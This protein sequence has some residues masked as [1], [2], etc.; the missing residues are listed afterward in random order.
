MRIGIPC[1]AAIVLAC[2]APSAG[3]QSRDGAEPT[4]REIPRIGSLLKRRRFEPIRLKTGWE[5]RVGLAGPGRVAGPWRILYCLARYA[6][7]GRPPQFTLD[8]K[9]RGRLLGPVVYR[10]ERADGKALLVGRHRARSAAPEGESLFAGGVPW[11]WKGRCLVEVLS[12]AGRVLGRT[13]FSAARPVPCYWHVFAESA[14]GNAWSFVVYSHSLA[15]MPHYD[16]LLPI[17]KAGGQ[18]SSVRRQKRADGTE[19]LLPEDQLPTELLW[20]R[21]GGG[22]RPQVALPA[23]PQGDGPLR[24]FLEKGEFLIHSPARMSDDVELGFLARWWLNDRPLVARTAAVARMINRGRAVRYENM[25]K[26]AFA[27]PETLKHAQVGD[28]VGLQ[29][30]YCPSGW[31]LIPP[32]PAAFLAQA[33]GPPQELTVP[34]L[35]NRLDFKVTRRLLDMARAGREKPSAR[36]PASQPAG[37]P[38]K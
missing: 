2:C 36:S 13:S 7:P 18:Q 11:A 21:G 4:V 26:V 20:P 12:P 14:D 1:A 16:G 33:A 37:E 23:A 27:L 9:L 5:V 19:E 15:A 10:V 28:R 6:G 17:A 29:V 35:S 25:L 22:K 34:V 31:E 3:G 24:L 38:A 30:A 32:A 8:G